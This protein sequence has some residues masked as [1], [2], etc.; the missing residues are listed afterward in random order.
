MPTAH[1][2]GI[3]IL[4]FP[5]EM[6]TVVPQNTTKFTTTVTTAYLIPHPRVSAQAAVDMWKPLKATWLSLH[7]QELII[8][9]SAARYG[10]W[11][12]TLQPHRQ[13]RTQVLSL[14]R[15]LR[16]QSCTCFQLS[17][18]QEQIAADVH[19][20]LTWFSSRLC[21]N[22]AFHKNILPV[23][24]LYPQIRLFVLQLQSSLKASWFKS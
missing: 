6:K 14:P 23:I 10:I 19:R 20:S 18:G 1:R 24:L 9:S 13:H 17:L 21:R 22:A 2:N 5:S 16:S 8:V 12:P 4:L 11:D 7:S 15:D 3:S